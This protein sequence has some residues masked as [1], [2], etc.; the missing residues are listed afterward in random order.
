MNSNV[1]I[2]IPKEVAQIISTLNDNNHKAYI[3]EAF[4]G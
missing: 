1:K 4:K 2:D 3:V